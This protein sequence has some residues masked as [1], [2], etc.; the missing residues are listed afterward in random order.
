MPSSRLGQ[1]ITFAI[2]ADADADFKKYIWVR[3]KKGDTVKK[4]A[5]RRGHPED[6]RKIARLNKIRSVTKVLR[7]RPKRKGDK[8]RIRV[9][10]TL[11]RGDTFSVLADDAP[12]RIVGGYQKLETIDRPGRTGLTHFVGYDPITMEVPIRFEQYLGRD[13]Q[14]I[15]DR[16]T[17]L[18]RMAGRGNFKGASA[19]PAPVLR[20][21]VTSDAGTVV[22][23]IPSNYQWSRQNPSAPLWR[24]ADISW[25]EDPVRDDSGRRLR[26]RAVV[27]VQQYT[28]L[29]LETRSVSQRSKNKP[30][31]DDDKGK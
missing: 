25:D 1:L 10:G 31:D 4:I 9:P 21:S 15:E 20:L 13:S 3:V 11:R 8:T 12:P 28:R 14:G 27:T 22:P 16:I 29:S 23:L 6:A 26:Q 24:V 17:L 18:E 19:G 5:S 2:E 30:K 7:H